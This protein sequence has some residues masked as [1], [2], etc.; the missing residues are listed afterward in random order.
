MRQKRWLSVSKKRQVKKSRRRDFH[1]HDP[2]YADRRAREGRGLE[3]R[4]SEVLVAMQRD[5]KI[6][7][8]KA[9]APRSTEDLGGHDFTVDFFKGEETCS[10]SFGIT[11]SWNSYKRYFQTHP[12]QECLKMF[13]DY[14]DEE[15]EQ[16]IMKISLK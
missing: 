11:I 3:A 10:I 14:S 2:D 6:H 9:H 4:M 15:M 8:F 5:G 7:S 12:G 13:M 1:F 16:E